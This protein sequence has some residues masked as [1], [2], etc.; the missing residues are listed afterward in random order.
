MEALRRAL[1]FTTGVVANPTS[2]RSTDSSW[3]SHPVLAVEDALDRL[4]LPVCRAQL[5]LEENGLVHE[6]AGQRVVAW[7]DVLDAVRGEARER[8]TAPIH[9]EQVV[10]EDRAARALPWRR[11]DAVSWLRANRLSVVADGRRV[12]VWGRVLDRLGE[13]AAPTPVAAS[14]AGRSRRTRLLATPGRIL[15]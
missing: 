7:S 12:V 8:R 11:R 10:S 15:D 2:A 3:S 9:A 1:A 4:P 13:V 6:M 5:W 14:R